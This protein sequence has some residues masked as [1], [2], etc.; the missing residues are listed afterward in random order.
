MPH[1][2]R[3]RPVVRAALRD[4]IKPP[5]EHRGSRIEVL[6]PERGH[7]LDWVRLDNFRLPRVAPYAL[8]PFRLRVR[9][10]VQVG[11]F[12]TSWMQPSGAERMATCWPDGTVTLDGPDD[13]D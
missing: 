8:G 6:N 5:F 7:T 4:A 13:D 9:R 11:M 2:G 1:T 3:L 12:H 10:V